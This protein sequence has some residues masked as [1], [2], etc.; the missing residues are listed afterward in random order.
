MSINFIKTKQFMN[1]VQTPINIYTEANPNPNSM[2]FVVN[3]M[4]IPE[5]VTFDFPDA[6]AAQEAPL[7]SEL[8]AK[9]NY[10][11]RV[12]MMNNFVTVTKQESLSWHDIAM[13]V[14]E[15]IK[16]Y[17]EE[18]KP[19]FSAKL[20][21]GYEEEFAQNQEEDSEL[22]KKIKGILD[23]YVKPA[24]E[25]DGGAI[26][27]HSYQ[28]DRKVVKLLLQGSCSGCPSSMVTLKMGIE[29]LLKRFLP[30]E[31]QEVEAEEV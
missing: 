13:E 26:T 21:K 19:L 30:N 2:K 11:E 7:A 23:E 8:F 1:Q 29:N 28:E 9:F 24:V 4:L 3:K 16:N 25:S 14:K 18:E 17:L 10:V 5:G 20:L 27:F 12:F 22:V 6:E 15:Y 31:V